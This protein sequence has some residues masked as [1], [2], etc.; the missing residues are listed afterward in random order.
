[1]KRELFRRALHFAACLAPLAAFVGGAA[2]ADEEPQSVIGKYSP[3]E[4]ASIDEA[5]ETLGSRIDPQPEGKIVEGIDVVTLDVIEARDPAPRALNAL[6]ATTRHYVI[7]REVLVNVGEPYQRIQCDETARNLRQLPQ[8]SLVICTATAGSTPDRVRVLVITKDVWS[9]RLG[10]DVSFIGGGLE[11]LQ[12]VPTETNLGGTHQIALA[13]YTYQPESQSLALGYR[14]PR[15]AGRRLSLAAETGITW[16]RQGQA[17]GSAGSL[18]VSTP[19]Y[20]ARTEWA[21]SVGTSWSDQMV[22]RY[23]NAKLAFY[24]GGNRPRQAQPG[25]DFF[26]TVS[27]DIPWEYRARRTSEAAY[28]TRSFGWAIKNDFTAGAEMNIRVFR[29][30]EVP[31]ADP[32][33]IAAF[34][35]ANVPTS[36]TRVGPFV[37]YRGYTSNFLRVL[38]FETLGLQEDFRLGHDVYLRVYPIAQALGSSRNFLGTYAAAQYTVPLGDGL[39]R[40]GLESTVEAEAQ[41]LSDASVAADLR[42]VTPR[43]GF[44]RLVVDAGL[45]NRYRNYLNRLSYLGGDGRLRGYPSSYF[46]GKD[47]VVYNFEYRSRPVEIFS[48]QLGGAAFYDV[49]HV[50]NGIDHLHPRHSLGVGFRILFPQLDRLVFRGDIGFPVAPPQ[51]DPGVS[52]Y[53]LSVAFEQAFSVPSV[54]GRFSSG[55]AAGWLG[56]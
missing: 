18:G 47:A 24:P 8:L 37:Q 50:A 25:G 4:Q 10:W 19:L 49:G 11:S 45:L 15:L 38:D 32:R 44:G 34:V 22:R 51:R 3:Y 36:D 17:E 43:L 39:V 1:M 31:G 46:V 33:A 16:N 6:H 28:V 23:Q 21:W 13:R 40:A 30:P 56:Q 7:E 35:Q 54:G 20:S 41:R 27:P 29:P 5:S 2:R 12:L 14:I 55:P 52:A 48:V 42:L 53:T 9:L 26:P